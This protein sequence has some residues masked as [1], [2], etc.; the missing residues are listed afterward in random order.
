MLSLP[1]RYLSL[2][3]VADP[4]NVQEKQVELFSTDFGPAKVREQGNAKINGKLKSE[5]AVITRDAYV[6]KGKARERGRTQSF[7]G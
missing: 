7:I 4:P 5:M 3:C 2:S 1:N 6:S